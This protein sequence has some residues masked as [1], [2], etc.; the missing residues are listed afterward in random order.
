VSEAVLLAAPAPSP[1]SPLDLARSRATHTR[2]PAALLKE[3]HSAALSSCPQLRI[4]GLVTIHEQPEVWSDT[5]TRGP[6]R[7]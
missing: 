6:P 4:V 3:V 2:H 5:Y 7:A 1:S